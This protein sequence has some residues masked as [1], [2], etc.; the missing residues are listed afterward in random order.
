M[1]QSLVTGS[2]SYLEES[3]GSLR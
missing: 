1:M 3:S 2:L